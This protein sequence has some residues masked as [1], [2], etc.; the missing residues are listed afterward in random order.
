MSA[1]SAS[2]EEEGGKGLEGLIAKGKAPVSD[3]LSPGRAPRG[4]VPKPLPPVPVLHLYPEQ[5]LHLAPDLPPE[6]LIQQATQR[7]PLVVDLEALVEYG[8]KVLAREVLGWQ[9][10]PDGSSAG[11]GKRSRR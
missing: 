8:T 11:A 10:V 6:E 1:V 7:Q 3:G 2:R 5:P 9:L 4:P